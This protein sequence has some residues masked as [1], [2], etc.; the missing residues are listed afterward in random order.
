MICKH[1]DCEN[2]AVA[3]GWCWKHYRRWKRHGNPD[4]VKNGSQTRKDKYGPDFHAKSGGAGG[5]ARKRGYFGNL[6]DEG[7]T[8][9]LKKLSQKAVK[10]KA[11][12]KLAAKQRVPIPRDKK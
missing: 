5:R 1:K 7:N 8:E 3:K 2:P 9:E 10:A 12:G 6:K 11:K 4:I